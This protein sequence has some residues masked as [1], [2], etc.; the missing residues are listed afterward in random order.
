MYTGESD[1]FG[2]TSIK[3]SLWYIV[4]I[5]LLADLIE[6]IEENQLAFIQNNLRHEKVSRNI[7]ICY[8][9]MVCVSLKF[10]S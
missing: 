3:P 5:Q 6:P 4:N 7:V 10:L 2:N 9:L 8:G 1:I